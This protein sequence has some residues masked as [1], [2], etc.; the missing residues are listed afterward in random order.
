MMLHS[1]TGGIL[2]RRLLLA[3]MT[4]T[5]LLSIGEVRARVAELSFEDRVK[6]QEAIERV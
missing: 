5:A 1:S 6:A 2:K 3:A 4:L